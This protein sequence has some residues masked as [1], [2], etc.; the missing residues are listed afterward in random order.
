[1]SEWVRRRGLGCYRMMVPGCFL[2]VTEHGCAAVRQLCRCPE[3]GAFPSAHGRHANRH[4]NCEQTPERARA[5]ALACSWIELTYRR[6]PQV[7][8]S[9]LSLRDLSASSS[10]RLVSHL[11]LSAT[12]PR[13]VSGQAAPTTSMGTVCTEAAEVLGGTGA[14]DGWRLRAHAWSMIECS[15][16]VAPPTAVIAAYG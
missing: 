7:K 2:V 6:C 11:C 9:I 4:R 12:L 3:C 1:M 8:G 5:R 14:A 10:R 13:G 16:D 15:C